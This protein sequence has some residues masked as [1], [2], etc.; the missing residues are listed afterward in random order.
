MCVGK[1]LNELL[2]VTTL[3]TPLS[4][5]ITNQEPL[6]AALNHGCW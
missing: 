1:D 6:P 2:A 3:A 5:L 4:A